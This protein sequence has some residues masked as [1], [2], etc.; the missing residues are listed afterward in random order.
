MCPPADGSNLFSYSA[1]DQATSAAAMWACV[2][3][4]LACFGCWAWVA[5][6]VA[7][8]AG[9]WSPVGLA[10]I[11]GWCAASWREAWQAVD[12]RG[13]GVR[14]AAVSRGAAT[15]AKHVATG[16]AIGVAADARRAPG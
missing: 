15:G 4:L 2:A 7:R 12:L 9:G 6:A 1:E 16:G 13:G 10:L 14:P 11:V 5:A 3:A 8:A